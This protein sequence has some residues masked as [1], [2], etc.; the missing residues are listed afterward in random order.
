[1]IDPVAT[2]EAVIA[3]ELESQIRPLTDAIPHPDNIRKH[4]LKAI[5]QSLRAHGQRSVIVVQKSTGF[6]VKGNG[7]WE[8]ARTLGW[9]KLA[10]SWQ[11]LNDEQAL[12]YLYADNRASDKAT[13]DRDKT[14]AGLKRMMEGP[15]LFDSGWTVDEFEDLLEEQAGIATLDPQG[16]EAAVAV[17]TR[18]GDKIPDAKAGPTERMKEVPVLLSLADHA[19]F[20][21]RIKRLQKIYG[22]TGVIATIVEAVRREADDRIAPLKLDNV[23]S[24]KLRVDVL[25]A[26]R[27]YFLTSGK[28]SFPLA[29]VAA[30]FQTAMRPIVVSPIREDAIAEG[31]IGMDDL[32]AEPEADAVAPVE[33][34]AVVAETLPEDDFAEIGG[35]S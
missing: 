12:A 24:E 19:E 9:D 32:M 1:M 2:F 27:D 13:Y 21:E 28:S 35:E 3:P 16:T 29:E 33:P 6:I 25:R 4:N 17:N 30:F 20:I 11:D 7:T 5:A 15:G 26:A 22:V 18:G 10:Q 31:Q 23:D 8:A 14:V 34:D